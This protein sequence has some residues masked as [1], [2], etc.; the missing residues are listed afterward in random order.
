MKKILITGSSGF[1]GFHLA[2]YLSKKNIVLGLDNHNN[3]YSKKIKQKRLMILK[4]KKNFLFK[5]IDLKNKKN[6]EKIF[7]NFKPE[8][9]FHIAGQPGVLYSFKNPNSYKINNTIVTKIIC[10][11]SKNNNVKK[12]I[13][14]SSSSIYGD[15]KKFPI[16][17]T[18]FTNP[19]N[20]YARTKLKAEKLIF[21]LKATFNGKKYSLFIFFFLIK[22]L[23][24]GIFPRFRNTLLSS[25][26][27]RHFISFKI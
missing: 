20:P 11:L 8:I 6:L 17:E 16:K 15:Q 4:K 2:K 27:I 7:K 24:R 19:K 14:A 22:P 10:E 3:Y 18:F 21:S 26:L 1:I 25:L 5:K 13:F 12:F 9:V 23:A